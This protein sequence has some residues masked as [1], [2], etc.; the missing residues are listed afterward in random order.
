MSL[1]QLA[2]HSELQAGSLY[3]YIESK[4]CLL[5]ELIEEHEYYLLHCLG[6]PPLARFDPRSALGHYLGAYLRFALPWRAGHTGG[7]SAGT[8]WR[9]YSAGIAHQVCATDG[10]AITACRR[11][12]CVIQSL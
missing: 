10:A 8:A 11:E 9:G 4:Q 5:F 6:K 2:E 7:R 12:S 3:H 1:R